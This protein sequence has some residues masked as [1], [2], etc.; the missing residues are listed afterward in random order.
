MMS[1]T[2]VFCFA[3][4]V[5]LYFL[6]K[7]IYRRIGLIWLSPAIVVPALTVILMIIARI[8]YSAY[9][10]DTRWIVWLLGPATVAFAV[11]I[12]E[13]RDTVRRH[14]LALFMGVCVG[15]TVALVSSLLLARAFHFDHQVARSLMAR[16]ISTPFAMALAGKTGGSPELVALFTII[17]GLVGMIAGDVVLSV[18]RLRSP[19]AH[20]ASF[21][22]AA[23]GF[24]T[25]RARERS[26]EEGVIA[27]LTMVLSGVL[28]VVVGPALTGAV[29]SLFG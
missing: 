20:G 16:S 3:W 2:P 14:W 17:T 22:A 21:G 27:S 12:Y 11:P 1:A 23:H 18:L 25:A 10:A 7:S 26:T 6:A 29:S 15:M 19:L 8:P 24:G 4:T 9:I 13:Y 28:M 5:V